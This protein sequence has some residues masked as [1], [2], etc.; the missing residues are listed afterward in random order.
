[1]KRKLNT[2]LVIVATVLV[3][4]I[5]IVFFIQRSRA[6]V[7]V[8][9]TYEVIGTAFS[10]SMIWNNGQ[11]VTEQV[12]SM[13]PFNRSYYMVT[14]DTASITVINLSHGGSVACHIYINDQIWKSSISQGTQKNVSCSG[15]IGRSK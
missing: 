11:G 6:K 5:V 15:V 14:G 9:V 13:L 12:D 3:V 8:K 7:A 1:V 10:A 4:A 2:I